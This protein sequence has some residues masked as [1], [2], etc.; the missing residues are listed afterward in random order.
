MLSLIW[1]DLRIQ[2]RNLWIVP[3][4]AIIMHVAFAN[5]PAGAYSTG[6][7]AVAYILI[8]NASVYDE[9]NN[10]DMLWCSLPVQRKTIVGAK[11][12]SSLIFMLIGLGSSALCGAVMRIINL[13]MPGN[14]ITVTNVLGIFVGIAIFISTY[15]PF[16]LKFGYAK[17][18]YLSIF[19]YLIMIFLPQFLVE[20]FQKNEEVMRSLANWLQNFG[21]TPQAIL[22]I[23]APTLLLILS[24]LV[25]VRIYRN[26]DIA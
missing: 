1:K 15:F 8:A 17:A 5:M 4:Y 26:K 25:A 18:R 9:K 24:Y 10:S 20:Q 16:Y 2:K 6:A 12:I 23:F 19:I 3:L 7:M 13:P 14:F 21:N 11:Y 22:A